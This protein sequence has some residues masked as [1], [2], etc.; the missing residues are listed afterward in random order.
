MLINKSQKIP[1]SREILI[2]FGHCQ[3]VDS[4]ERC[5]LDIPSWEGKIAV[6]D[7]IVNSQLLV[8]TFYS[9]LPLT[10]FIGL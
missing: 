3:V 1:A 10:L 6:V 7:K 2:D 9:P 8:N 4:L 5:Q